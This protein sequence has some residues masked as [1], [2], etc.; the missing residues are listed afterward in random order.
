[1]KLLLQKHQEQFWPHVDFG[2]GAPGE[3]WNW[4]GAVDPSG[5]GHFG[6]QE[7]RVSAHKGAYEMRYGEVPTGNNVCHHCDN[8]LCCNPDHLF[9]GTQK[10]NLADMVRKGRSAK[11][12]HHGMSRL[13]ESQARI[14]REKKRWR[15]GDETAFARKF[16]VSVSC[17]SAVKHGTTWRV[18]L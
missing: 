12:S 2:T 7:H 5:Y 15:R 17:V 1:M 16:R 13:T 9:A 8:R 4:K 18:T 11:G 6:K 3:C 10:E 14:I